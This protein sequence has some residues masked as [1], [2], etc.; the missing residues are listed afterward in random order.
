MTDFTPDYSVALSFK[1]HSC[2]SCG[3]TRLAC[4]ASVV[5]RSSLSSLY[6]RNVIESSSD[7]WGQIFSSYSDFAE[8]PSPF[9]AVPTLASSLMRPKLRIPP[10][11]LN[12]PF[13]RCSFAILSS[14]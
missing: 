12:S 8:S 3:T 7:G 5:C 10:V 4:C 6:V 9:D 1:P 11:A 2:S 14:C 13:L